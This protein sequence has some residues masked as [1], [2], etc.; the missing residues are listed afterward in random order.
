MFHIPMRRMTEGQ[1]FEEDTEARRIYTNLSNLIKTGRKIK[2]EVE[3]QPLTS[4]R[5]YVKVEG[6]ECIHIRRFG[7]EKK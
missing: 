3:S 5:N 4:A 1:P 2:K 6:I 7:A